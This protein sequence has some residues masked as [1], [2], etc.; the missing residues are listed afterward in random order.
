MKVELTEAGEDQYLLAWQTFL[1]YEVANDAQIL[2][3]THD[4]CQTSQLYFFFFIPS[5][6]GEGV[7]ASSMMSNVDTA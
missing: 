5:G 6:G 1:E 3:S 4:T 2:Q 7:T